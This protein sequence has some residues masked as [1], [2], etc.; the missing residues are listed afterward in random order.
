MGNET[1]RIIKL[2]IA[3]YKA[4]QDS[5]QHHDNLLWYVS[6]IVWGG[7]LILL[8][9]C[10]ENIHG[11]LSR[12]LIFWVGIFCILLNLCVWGTLGDRSTGGV[13]ISK[14][15][16]DLISIVVFAILKD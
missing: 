4:A 16:W 14:I 15:N 1:D 12:F 7:N 13:V 5:A 11:A 6:S 10:L 3:E 9:S 8:G 2:R